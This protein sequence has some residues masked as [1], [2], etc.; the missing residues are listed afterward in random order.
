[1]RENGRNARGRRKFIPTADSNH[2]LEVC[3]N[4]LNQE[5]QAEY[6]SAYA[7]YI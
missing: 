2:G 3:D 1:M 4:V 6:V 7:G 5:F